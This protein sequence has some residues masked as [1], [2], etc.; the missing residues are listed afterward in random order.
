MFKITQGKGFHI[1]FENGLTLSTQ[2]GP[3]NHCSNYNSS[4]Y[5]SVL[6]T[7]ESF[8]CEIAVWDENSEWFTKEIQKIFKH[9]RYRVALRK[10]WI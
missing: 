10:G 9:A 1:T 4:N 6:K 8:D 5:L 2:I 3:K 7:V